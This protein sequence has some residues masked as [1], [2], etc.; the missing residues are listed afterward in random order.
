M[1]ISDADKQRARKHLGYMGVTVA[2]SFAFGVPQ[3]TTTQYMLESA[4]ERVMAVAEADVVKLLDRL[5]CIDEALFQAHGDLFAVRVADLEMN[6][7]QPDALEIEYARWA[8]RLAD[9][10]GVMPY[11][12]AP[13]FKS[14]M[15]GGV[16]NIRIGR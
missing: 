14:L 5:D 1:A 2:S 9:M 6:L 16:G 7:G 12:F 3:L 8:Q 11:P 4:I 15:G 10:L 13:R